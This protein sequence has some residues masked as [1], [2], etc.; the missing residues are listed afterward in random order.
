MNADLRDLDVSGLAAAF[1]TRLAV[2]QATLLARLGAPQ[3]DPTVLTERRAE[4][5]GIRARLKA[6]PASRT[7]VE[8]LLSAMAAA[9]PACESVADAATDSR[10]ADYY[11]QL[12]WPATSFFA[13]LNEQG[14]WSELMLFFRSVFL[15]GTSVAMP[16]LLF[17]APLVLAYLAPSTVGAEPMTFKRYMDILQRAL[18]QAMPSSLGKARF[19]GRGGFPE[20][21]EQF[22]HVGLA[23]AMFVGSSWNQITAALGLRRVA[24][25]M[26]E[27][28]DAV[29][30]MATSVCELAGLLGVS[31]PAEVTECWT[32]PMGGSLA[33]FGTAWN[34]PDRVRILLAE[35]GRLDML[36]AVALCKR[37]CF[38]TLS[39]GQKGL[40]L[41]DLYHPGLEP[42]ARVYNT[43][44]MCRDSSDGSHVL[45][46]GPNRGGK[47]TLLK[48]LGAAVLMSQTVGVVFARSATLP[49]FHAIVTALNPADRLGAL[50]LF[51]AEIEFAKGVRATIAGAKGPVFLMMDEIFHGTNA[52]DGVEASQVFLDEL[53]GAED[54]PGVPVYSVVSTHYMELPKRYGDG[55]AQ[56]LC[57]EASVSPTDPDRLVY[58]YRL[59]PGVNQYS[60]VREILRER[61]LLGQKTSASAAE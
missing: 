33:T 23:I 8:E 49:V 55:R 45:L 24:T 19:A 10:H 41:V 26:R 46:T 44:R 5:R 12:L 11:N 52:H 58:S 31:V 20:L 54:E 6:D 47:S 16:V 14:W 21:A 17:A 29:R 60:S 32:T 37:T 9:E 61:G 48:A 36:A 39:E 25:D 4:M 2:G 13:W 50:S 43:V 42:G 1:P 30:Q 18:R 28:A 15:P 27:R 7:R 51:E 59:R 38:P 57:M 34:H 56:L 22:I 3:A 53:Y 40:E 35:A